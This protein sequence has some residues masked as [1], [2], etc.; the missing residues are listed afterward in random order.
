MRPLPQLNL[1]ANRIYHLL[2]KC[3]TPSHINQIQA[4][5]ILHNLHS[6]TRIAHQFITACRSLNLLDSAFFLYTGLQKPHIF[7]CNTLIQAFSHTQYHHH[8]ISL[9]THMHKNSVI[10][11]NYSFPFVLKSISDLKNLKLGQCVHTQIVKMGHLDDIYVQNSLLN[12]YA[13]CGKM[14]LCC[15][16]FDEMSQRDVVSWTVMITGYREDG[17][18]D[19][20]LMAFEQMQ[21]AGVAPNRVT[22]VNALAVCASFN[23][24]DMGV[25]IHDFIR[26]SG[27]ELDVILGTSL[28]DMYGKCGRIEEVLGVFESMK[29]KNVFTWNAVIKGLALIKNGEEAIRWFFRMD[30]EGVQ[31]DEVTLIAVLCACVHSGLVPMGRKIFSSLTDGEYGFSPGV[32]H[33]ATMVDLLARSGYLE[34]ALKV[35]KDMPFE[36]NRNVWGALLSGCTAQGDLELSVFAATKLVEL[37]PDNSAY[38]IVLS[39]LYADM[40]R[41]SD[42]EKVRQ[43][44]KVRG[45]KKDLGSSLVDLEPH[46]HV[47]KSF[48]RKIWIG[49]KVAMAISKALVASLVFSL[50]V[51]HL[52]QATETNELIAGELVL[53]GAYCRQGQGCAR[54]HAGHAVLGATVSPLVLQATWRPVPAMP[55]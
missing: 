20:A 35:I 38:Y 45:L 51:M 39:N 31:P 12:G 1:A 52:V 11:N 44:M 48:R 40:G 10:P 49:T 30:Q 25:W 24:I 29:E 22:M 36:P 13:S 42:V 18:L 37:V 21:C 50:L 26:R 41:W 54:G 7:I 47:I 28:I 19:D 34:D 14:D 27:W 32:K 3:T 17:K 55:K 46:E 16:V 23:A 53:L 8:S 9:Y 43:L 2:N 15:R 4:Q 33:Y 5:L 6:N